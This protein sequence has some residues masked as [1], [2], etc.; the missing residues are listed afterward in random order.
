MSSTQDK[1]IVS[2]HSEKPDLQDSAHKRS[3]RRKMLRNGLAA[4]AATLGAGIV[5]EKNV[6]VAHAAPLDNPGNFSSSNP[7]VPAVTAT[8]TNGATGVQI[9]SD[10]GDGL[11]AQSTSGGD[12]IHAIG[13]GGSKSA[14]FAEGGNSNAV[15]ATSSGSGKSAVF[16]FNSSSTG[17]GI[18]GEGDTGV[19]V[20][21]GTTSG[22]AV[23]ATGGTTGIAVQAIGGSVALNVQGTMQVQGSSVGQATIPAGSSSVTVT[24]SAATTSSIILLTLLGKSKGVLWVTRAAGSFTIHASAVQS[25]SLSI[26][27]L[28]IN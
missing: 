24:T 2:Q 8:G 11:V 12:A 3:S 27:Y 20:H 13:P 16:G 5:L 23:Q 7:S 26:A 22:V 25:S 21:G 1:E 18:Y 17:Y 9:T 15:Y 19:A 14:V 28:I 10:T 4:A 6:G